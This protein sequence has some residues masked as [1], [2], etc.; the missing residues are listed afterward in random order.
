MATAINVSQYNFSTGLMYD[1]RQDNVPILVKDI[2]SVDPASVYGV[3]SLGQFYFPNVRGKITVNEAGV[4]KE[5]Y[6]HQTPAQ[7]ATLINA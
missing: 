6:V 3:Y 4:L 1:S 2:V 7:I 5:V